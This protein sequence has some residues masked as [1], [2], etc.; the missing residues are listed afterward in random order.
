M[1]PVPASPPTLRTRAIR[2]SLLLVLVVLAAG[3]WF[4][5][6]PSVNATSTAATLD[7]QILASIN[8]DRA[9]LGL[10]ALRLDSRLVGWSAD[11]SAWMAGRGVM[12]HTS[13]DGSP[14]NLYNVMRIT[15][16]QC[17][18]AIAYTNATPGPAAGA[19]LYN[20]W[21]GS[22]DHYALIT[23]NTFNYIGIGITYRPANGTTYASILFLEGPDRSLPIASLTNGSVNGGTVQWGWTAHDPILQTH[24]AGVKDYDIELRSN[25]GS[26]RMIRANSVTLSYTLRNQLPGSTWALRVRARDNAGNVSGWVTSATIVVH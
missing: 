16:Y 22:P 25:N 4:G 5:R 26:W 24:T 18:E 1:R 21:K 15:W 3:V 17:G 23:S 13:Y 6:P 19:F 14:C 2:H 10:H 20:L 8:K 12:T 7:A 9:S 11:R